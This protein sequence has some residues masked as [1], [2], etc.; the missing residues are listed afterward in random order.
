MQRVAGDRQI[1]RGKGDTSGGIEVIVLSDQSFPGIL[2]CKCLKIAR[3]EDAK[4]DELA[5]EWLDIT[6]NKEVPRGTVVLLGSLSHMKSAGTAGYCEDFFNAACVIMEAHGGK[7]DVLPLPII[8]TASTDCAITICTLAEVNR[9]MEIVFA[10]DDRYPA[11]SFRLAGTI[12][13]CNDKT[14]CQLD[15]ATNLK[16][17]SAGATSSGNGAPESSSCVVFPPLWSKFL[18]GKSFS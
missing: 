16:L 6:R 15:Y 1:I 13:S 2:P 14:S 9:W 4:L 12:L 8:C 18:C 17:N 7:V 5:K 10:G 3:P 11:D